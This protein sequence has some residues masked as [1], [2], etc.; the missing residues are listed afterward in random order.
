MKRNLLILATLA[1]GLHS[2]SAVALGQLVQ[3]GPGY[4]K[5]PFVRVYSDPG[6]G[7][8]GGAYVR[9]PFV[10]V[11]GNGPRGRFA[12]QPVPP[13]PEELSQYD[14]RSLRT[15]IRELSKYLDSQLSTLA[16]GDQW[17]AHLKTA[18]IRDLVRDEN[19]PPS[20]HVLAQLPR[21][22]ASFEST[23][24]N[25]EYRTISGLD[26][27]RSLNDALIEF[28][29]PPDLRLRKQLYFAVADLN[30]SLESMRAEAAWQRVLALPEGLALAPDAVPQSAT[31]VE[32]SDV[33]KA[34]AHYESI[35]RN[36]QYRSIAA[37]PAFRAIQDRLGEY[38]A[39]S[40][41]PTPA[42]PRV[43]AEELPA[44]RSIR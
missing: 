14:W 13:T 1:I 18:E 35:A 24:E 36:G 40:R 9:A 27:F 19:A 34:L 4:V 30:Q 43:G 26:G 3:V 5:A 21:I 10:E 32:T 29:A 16:T 8:R 31:T 28:A 6:N 22:L 20:D 25:P 11:Y 17:K 7:G 41:S 12:R 38:L 15:T 2:L 33:A 39:A 23:R 42:A 44:P 37:I